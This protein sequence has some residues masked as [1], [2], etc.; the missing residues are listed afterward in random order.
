MKVMVHCD[1]DGAWSME[2]WRWRWRR[3]RKNPI[4]HD[5]WRQEG[6]S[7]RLRVEGIFQ[8]LAATQASKYPRGSIVRWKLE[9]AEISTEI[10]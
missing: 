1:D 7:V 2:R 10:S 8:Y 5:A 9:E 6:A 3:W 4:Q